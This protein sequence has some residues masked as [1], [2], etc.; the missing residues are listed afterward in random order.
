MAFKFCFKALKHGFK[1]PPKE[2]KKVF[3]WYVV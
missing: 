2:D 3:S 1:L